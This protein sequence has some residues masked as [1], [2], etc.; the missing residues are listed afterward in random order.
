MKKKKGIFKPRAIYVIV[1][2]SFSQ[3]EI[4]DS[5]GFKKDAE[6]IC[7]QLERKARRNEKNNDYYEIHKSNFVGRRKVEPKDLPVEE[8]EDEDYKIKF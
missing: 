2:R 7:N 3:I 1:R 6:T 5:F 8:I 4:L